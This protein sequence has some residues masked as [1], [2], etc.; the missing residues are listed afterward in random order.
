MINSI[1][2][3]I[4][5][6]LDNYIIKE[7][8]DIPEK[9]VKKHEWIIDASLIYEKNG[10]FTNMTFDELKKILSIECHYGKSITLLRFYNYILSTLHKKKTDSTYGVGFTSV[11]TMVDKMGLNQKTIYSYLIELEQHELMHVYRPQI[12]IVKKDGTIKEIPSTYGRFEDK[13]KIDRIGR[14]YENKQNNKK[15]P[16]KNNNNRA[17]SQKYV[18]IKKCIDEGRCIPDKYKDELK[19]IYLVAFE[20]NKKYNQESRKDKIKDLTMF[21]NYE[22]YKGEK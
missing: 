17:L 21:K 5:N 10:Y 4:E 16:R 20:L 12:S 1:I 8:K 19:D 7:I 13:E 3:G 11:E 15:L 14:E 18:Q 2:S 9:N 6:L 22:F